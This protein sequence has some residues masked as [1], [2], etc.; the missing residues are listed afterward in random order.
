MKTKPRESG[1][2]VQHDQIK[3]NMKKNFLTKR[4]ILTLQV[5]KVGKGYQDLETSEKKIE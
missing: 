3:F 4:V 5:V 2:K 1:I